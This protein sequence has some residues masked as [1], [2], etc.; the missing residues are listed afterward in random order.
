VL[1]RLMGHSL[2]SIGT[3]VA[4]AALTAPSRPAGREGMSRRY[5]KVPVAWAQSRPFVVEHRCL[6]RTGQRGWCLCST[7]PRARSSD[8]FGG[9]HEAGLHL[10]GDHARAVARASSCTAARAAWPWPRPAGHQQAA[11]GHFPRS[12]VRL[13][14]GRVRVDLGA[15]RRRKR[16][17]SQPRCL[18]RTGCGR[19]R[20]GHVAHRRPQRTVHAR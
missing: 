7:C 3:G 16:C 1:T 11:M 17:S 12:W 13:G 15:A 9:L 5:L 10:D 18:R 6:R 14:P 4:D 2:G 19:K 20:N 8:A